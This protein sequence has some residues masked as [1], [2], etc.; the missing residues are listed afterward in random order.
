MVE[1]RIIVVMTNWIHS[2]KTRRPRIARAARSAAR[3]GNTLGAT[4]SLHVYPER[5]ERMAD[6]QHAL[7]SMR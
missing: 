5:S 7:L 4:E 1:A 6:R 2:L 3:P